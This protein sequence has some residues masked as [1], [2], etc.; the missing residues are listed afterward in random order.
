VIIGRY[1]SR[2]TIRYAAITQATPLL[3]TLDV[4]VMPMSETGNVETVTRA[5]AADSDPVWSPD[6]R[7]LLFRSLQDGR[8]HL[9]THAAHD[10]DAADAIVPMSSTDET[11]TDW[12]GD[13]IVVHAAGAKGDLDLWTVSQKTAREVIA[14]TGFNESDGRLAPD[15]RWLAYVSD[16]SG[17]PDV[18]AAPWPRGPR[19]RV[20][21]AE[22]T[23]PRWSRDGRALFFLR[24]TQIMR[25][26]VSG[27]AF[28]TPREIL[29]LRGIRD[30]DVAHQRDALLALIP[31]AS[32][33]NATTSMIV[34]WRSL[35]Q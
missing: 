18:Y 19:V 20:S 6:S 4:V 33:T 26:D 29:D 9:Y 7:T 16:E 25:S 2:P 1:A 23:R 8:P 22:G 21:F 12:R 35:V 32:S 31:A 30:F 13:R 5:V 14:D 10:Q 3:R 27:T 34:D 28:T 11:P 24:G 15:G 17:Q